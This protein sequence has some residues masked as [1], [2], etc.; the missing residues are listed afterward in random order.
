MSNHETLLYFIYNLIS[1]L[2]E[3]ELVTRLLLNTLETSHVFVLGLMVISQPDNVQRYW[4]HKFV[5]PSEKMKNE[6]DK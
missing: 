1:N 5:H 4:V 3:R 6:R 2:T